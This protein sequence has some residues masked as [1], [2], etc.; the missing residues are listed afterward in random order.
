[1][2]AM[3]ILKSPCQMNTRSKTDVSPFTRRYLSS[4]LSCASSTTGMFS[5]DS[6]TSLANWVAGMSSMWSV[7]MTRSNL[8][9]SFASAIASFPLETLVNSGEWLRLNPWYSFRIS[10]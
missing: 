9:S 8:R 7:V 10:S 1:M 5:P 2:I 3:M 6:L 4:L